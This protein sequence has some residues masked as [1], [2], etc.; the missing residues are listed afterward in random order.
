MLTSRPE[1][2]LVF[3]KDKMKELGLS[4]DTVK[5]MI[6]GS[7]VLIPLGLY[8]FNRYGKFQLLSMVTLQQLKH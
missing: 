2:Q 8:T 7:D 5:N 4:E 6:K 3:K 1:V